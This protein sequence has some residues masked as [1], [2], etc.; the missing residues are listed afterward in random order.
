VWIFAD[1]GQA[2]ADLLRQALSRGVKPR[3]VGTRLSADCSHCCL[4]GYPGC[5]LM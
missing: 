2:V 5:R 3:Y 1:E 4:P